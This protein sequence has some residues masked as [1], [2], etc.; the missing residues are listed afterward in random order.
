MRMAAQMCS[1]YTTTCRLAS[2]QPT[3]KPAGGW[4]STNSRHSSR[5]AR[6]NKAWC[7]MSSVTP[8]NK[9]QLTFPEVV[10]YLRF[11]DAQ[12]KGHE[13]IKNVL[14]IETYDILSNF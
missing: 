2:R 4:H 11:G 1:P 7:A 14:H 10:L 12:G 8:K 5:R 3:T 9:K 6:T 13:S